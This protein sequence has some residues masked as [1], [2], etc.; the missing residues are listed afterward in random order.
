MIELTLNKMRSRS[1]RSQ[2]IPKLCFAV[3][4]CGGGCQCAALSTQRFPQGER[5]EQE[6]YHCHL[7]IE[8]ILVSAASEKGRALYVSFMSDLE[9]ELLAAEEPMLSLELI[10]LQQDMNCVC[11][12][13]TTR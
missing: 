13:V 7:F 6:H 11:T 2:H 10:F 8:K 3:A 12:A 4:L 5:R 1:E 9:S